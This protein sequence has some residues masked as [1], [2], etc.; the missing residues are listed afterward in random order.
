MKLIDLEKA[1]AQHTGEFHCELIR[2]REK[3]KTVHFFHEVTPPAE[4]S[5]LPQIGR[6]KDFYDTFGSV[7]FYYDEK[8]GEAAK[9]IAPISEWPGLHEDF[10]EWTRH[11]DDEERSE[12]LPDWI[13]SC[14]VI[15]E[16]P[17]S[18][19]YILMPTEGEMA[20]HV[21]EFD[22]DGFEFSEEAKNVVEYVEKLLHPDSSRLVE[23]A[24][25][26]R[27]VEG[28]YSVQWWICKM[29]DNKGHEVSINM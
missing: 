20:G 14:L 26:M 10:S 19:N 27:F 6:L 28:D 29:T 15:G 3:T 8:S 22:H 24:S 18:G 13:G 12:V 21:F 23:I 11:L 16:T 25:H 1:V 7:V 5:D 9:H 2:E 17:H 4:S